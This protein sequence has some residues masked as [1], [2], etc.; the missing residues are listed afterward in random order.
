MVPNCFW[1]MR[2]IFQITRTSFHPEF[3]WWNLHRTFRKAPKSSAPSQRWSQ[4]AWAA[5]K[6]RPWQPKLWNGIRRWDNIGTG[7]SWEFVEYGK[8]MRHKEL[9]TLDVAER[10]LWN[11][12]ETILKNGSNSS[13]N[14]I[15]SSHK[16][17]FCKDASEKHYPNLVIQTWFY[18]R[19]VRPIM[20]MFGI[21]QH[22]SSSRNG[23][24]CWKVMGSRS[25]ASCSLYYYWMPDKHNKHMPILSIISHYMQVLMEFQHMQPPVHQY[26][27]PRKFS[28]KHRQLNA[29]LGAP[30]SLHPHFF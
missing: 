25:W 27:K 18:C 13:R 20:Q 30:S 19:Y 3:P 2:F 11:I 4:T 15:C 7:T 9:K 23:N 22:V 8:M 5:A 10:K 24:I 6:E 16:T 12:M 26:S 29:T 1:K 17:L 28:H 14:H 21:F